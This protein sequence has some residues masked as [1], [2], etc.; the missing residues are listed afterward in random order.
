MKNKSRNINGAAALSVLET[1]APSDLKQVRQLVED[2]V[3]SDI[4]AYLESISAGDASPTV[5]SGLSTAAIAGGQWGFENLVTRLEIANLNI[6]NLDM[7]ANEILTLVYRHTSILNYVRIKITAVQSIVKS[8]LSKTASR[9]SKSEMELILGA[10][11]TDQLT[12]SKWGEE[13]EAL[14]QKQATSTGQVN[15]RSVSTYS[16]LWKSYL[17][18]KILT[19]LDIELASDKN[20]FIAVRIKPLLKYKE[21]SS[22]QI[23]RLLADSAKQFN[24]VTNSKANKKVNNTSN[25]ITYKKDLGGRMLQITYNLEGI[26]P[27]L[28][29]PILNSVRG[30]LLIDPKQQKLSVDMS[31]DSSQVVVE[32]EKP[33][34][35]DIDTLRIQLG[36]LASNV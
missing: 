35:N 26:D 11:I 20:D 31:N 29:Q 28:I 22:T 5:I 34:K 19:S 15:S 18:E 4:A 36:A 13:A 10:Q 1:E 23:K 27:D 8:L 25:L 21:P 24:F 6:K 9:T 33:T 2:A 3:E 12:L 7:A 16:K 17:E 30:Q 32:L 14:F